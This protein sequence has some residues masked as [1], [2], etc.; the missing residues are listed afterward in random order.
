MKKLLLM[1]IAAMSIGI[2]AQAQTTET[3]VKKTSTPG[4]KIHNAF[5]KHKRHNGYVVKTKRH[6][7]KTKKTVNY[8][9]GTTVIKKD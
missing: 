5:S 9:K 4:Q 1:L 8:E 7:H 2:C 3:K 6:G